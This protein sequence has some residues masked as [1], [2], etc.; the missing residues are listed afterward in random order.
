MMKGDKS[1]SI[2]YSPLSLREDP[3][4]DRASEYYTHFS[5]IRTS[6]RRG[7]MRYRCR[8][9]LHEFECSGKMR[10]IQHILGHDLSISKER[11]VRS[12]PVPHSPLKNDLL[13]Q[14]LSTVDDRADLSRPKRA[15]RKG[16]AIISPL[17]SQSDDSNDLSLPELVLPSLKRTS[18]FPLLCFD[19]LSALNTHSQAN[20]V[21]MEFFQKYNIP[22]EAVEQPQFQHFVES[23]Y[24]TDENYYPSINVAFAE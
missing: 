15:T 24:A 8:T 14:Y 5:A 23:I 10:R 11:N 13:Q 16:R 22:L 2:A 17:T 20:Q 3:I 18:S 4:S 9:C 7:Q 19:A 21:L 12:C 6:N 1:K